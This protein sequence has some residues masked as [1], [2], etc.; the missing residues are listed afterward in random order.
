MLRERLFDKGHNWLGPASNKGDGELPAKAIDHLVWAVPNLDDAAESLAAAGFTLTPRAQH[1]PGMGTAN[2]LVQLANKSFLELLEVDR[3][4][5]ID[6][7]D[8]TGTPPIF[9]F[10]RYTQSFLANGAGLSQ[11]VI[12]SDNNIHDADR[13]AQAGFGG[14]SPLD[15]GRTATQPDGSHR[16]V[17]FSLAFAW[18]SS[19]PWLGCFACQNRF[20]EN[21]WKPEFQRHENGASGIKGVVVSAPDCGAAAD[22]LA[23]VG[24]SVVQPMRDGMLIEL[25]NDQRIE[26]LSPDEFARRVPQAPPMQ[27]DEAVFAALLMSYEGTDVAPVGETALGRSVILAT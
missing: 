18:T 2:R 15:F 4:A 6:K 24:G 12:A 26:V 19:L 21:F 1:P 16:E 3:P 13:F 27:R 7:H 17:A 23:K 10:G 20:P 9:G 11:L 22:F 5:A 14:F 25:A 8:P